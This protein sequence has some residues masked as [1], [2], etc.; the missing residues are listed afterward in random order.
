M[1]KHNILKMELLSLIMALCLLLGGCGAP[2]ET[3]E[4]S[5][6]PL[7]QSETSAKTVEFVD[8]VYSQDKAQGKSDAYIDTSSSSDGYVG[9]SV[10]NEKRIKFQVIKGDVKYN[11][12]VPNDGTPTIFPLQFGDGS[13]KLRVMKNTKDNKY[14]EL[15]STTID[16]KLSSEF[17]PFIR[18]SSYVNYGKDSNCTKKAVEIA[19]QSK[20]SLGIISGVYSYV[21]KNI[22]YDTEKAKTV[23]SGYL[24]DPDETL[25]TGKGICFDYASLAASMLRSQGIPTKLIFGYV[26]PNGLYHAWNMFYTEQTGW[27]TVKFEAKGDDWTRMDLTFSAGGAGADFIGNGTNYTDVYYY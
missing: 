11:Y 19:A 9:V 4:E 20:D 2:V 8:A 7:S 24:P 12:D 17:S 23:K 6:T 13:Y 25:S 5:E 22:K 27:V 10:K 3:L 14:S 18:P 21:T 16:V 26:A 1:K 15:Y